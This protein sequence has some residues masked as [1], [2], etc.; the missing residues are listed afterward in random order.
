MPKTA[1]QLRA[2]IQGLVREYHAAAFAAK[3]FE[4]G[5]TPVPY[6][7]RV[8]DADEVAHLVDSALHFCLT[9]GRFASRFGKAFVEVLSLR[10]AL[11]V[12]SRCSAHLLALPALT[13]PQL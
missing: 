1:D 12:Y 3:P 2:E 4:P 8:L 13:S 7:G 10:H 5:R 11:L 6:A 9:A